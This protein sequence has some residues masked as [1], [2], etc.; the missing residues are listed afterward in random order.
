MRMSAAAARYTAL[1]VAALSDAFTLRSSTKA[2]QK[3]LA[4]PM[5]TLCG[6]AVTLVDFVADGELMA[7]GD[8]ELVPLG[9]VELVP[10]GV[11]D[12]AELTDLVAPEEHPASSAT[13]TNVRESRRI[14]KTPL[15][16]PRMRQKS[17]FVIVCVPATNLAYEP[18]ASNRNV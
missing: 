17:P 7:L 18:D 14:L 4:P 15:F 13:M 2:P 8:V 9:D 16:D 11:D 12:F 10:V 6:V 5:M 3:F 1:A